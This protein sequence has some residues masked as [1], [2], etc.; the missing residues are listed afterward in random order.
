MKRILALLLV[1][2]AVLAVGCSGGGSPKATTPETKFDF[3]NVVMTND[4][5][6]AKKHEFFIKNEGTADLKLSDLQVKLLEG[7]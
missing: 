3:G 5:N 4:H 2:T 7:C 6:D 1:L